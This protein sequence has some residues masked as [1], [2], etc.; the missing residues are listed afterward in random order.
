LQTG[1]EVEELIAP[2]I[3]PTLAAVE[4]PVGLSYSATLVS[5]IV[6]VFHLVMILQR[7]AKM[8]DMRE[9]LLGNDV[10]LQLEGAKYFRKTLAIGETLSFNY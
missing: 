9:L 3:E 7:L 5:I 2:S 8:N 6:V 4:N 1:E 10:E